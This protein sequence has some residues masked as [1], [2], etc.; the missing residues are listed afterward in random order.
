VS[1]SNRTP[2]S[3]VIQPPPDTH[4]T[5]F[6]DWIAH[7]FSTCHSAAFQTFMTRSLNCFTIDDLVAT[8]IGFVRPVLCV[9][10]TTATAHSCFAG[11]V[12]PWIAVSRPIRT[13]DKPQSGIAITRSSFVPL[14]SP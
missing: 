14:L 7:N 3:F 12:E 6:W 8:V 2:P 10:D 1:A 13:P 4:V 11:S 9:C 5:Y